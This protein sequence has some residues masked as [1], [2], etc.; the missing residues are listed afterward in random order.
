VNSI[1]GCG[2]IDSNLRFNLWLL[3]DTLFVD[4]E[5]FVFFR[6]ECGELPLEVGEDDPL[7]PNFLL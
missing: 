7:I 2:G 5:F 4:E 6:A 1:D 3:R